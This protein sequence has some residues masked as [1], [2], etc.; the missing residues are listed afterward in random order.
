M[1]LSTCGLYEFTGRTHALGS[2][3]IHYY[4][5]L[6]ELGILANVAF[7]EETY[8]NQWETLEE[9]FEDQAWMFHNMTD[10][11]KERIKIYLDQ[12]LSCQNGQWKLPYERKCY[13]AVMW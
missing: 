6:H 9:A 4:N 7:I 2:D 8:R 13:W 5:I 10:Y 11:E 12:H 3:F 1:A